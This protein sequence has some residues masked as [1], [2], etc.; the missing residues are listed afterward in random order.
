VL[1]T[2]AS[3]WL[4]IAGFVAMAGMAGYL[5][6]HLRKLMNDKPGKDGWN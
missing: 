6:L 2:S 3:G 4:S 1:F 5:F